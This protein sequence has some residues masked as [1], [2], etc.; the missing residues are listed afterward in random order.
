MDSPTVRHEKRFVKW[1]EKKYDR[2][3]RIKKGFMRDF[4][5]KLNLLLNN[6][7]TFIFTDDNELFAIYDKAW[8]S[9]LAGE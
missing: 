4:V 9:T 6:K 1:L 8:D 3:E 5:K 2:A 7:D